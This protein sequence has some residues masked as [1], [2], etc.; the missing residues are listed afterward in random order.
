M[1]LAGEKDYCQLAEM[2]WQ[3]CEEDDREYGEES[4]KGVDKE[5]FFREFTAFLRKNPAYQIFVAEKDGTLLSAIFVYRVPKVPK[6]N[7]K[8]RSIAYLTNVFTLPAYRSQGIGSALLN[9]IKEALL[10]EKC[11]L[12]FAWPSRKSVKWYAANGFRLKNGIVE[13]I[14]MEE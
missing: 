11:E 10:A 8:S 6:P 12:A 1:R 5:D 4:L 14:L 13:C 7:G 3:H 2:K 9:F